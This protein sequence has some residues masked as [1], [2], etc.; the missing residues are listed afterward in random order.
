MNHQ[1]STNQPSQ[2]HGMNDQNSRIYKSSTPHDNPADY[3]ITRLEALQARLRYLLSQNTAS[4]EFDGTAFSPFV[5]SS[6]SYQEKI[7][8]LNSLLLFEED[9]FTRLHLYESINEFQSASDAHDRHIASLRSLIKDERRRQKGEYVP[10]R[11]QFDISLLK[12]IPI[13]HFI[14]DPSLCIRSPKGIFYRCEFHSEKTPSMLVDNDNH[15]H[16]FGGCGA[17]GDNI[18][19]IMQKHRMTFMEACR[20]LKDF[21]G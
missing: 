21:C 6:V 14:S 7:S 18:A 15:F 1:T 16:C 19:F 2:F 4:L 10:E 17:H 8:R 3:G 12:E 5:L 13:H 9:E 11:K 20:Y